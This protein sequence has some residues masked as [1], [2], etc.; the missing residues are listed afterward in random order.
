MVIFC[1]F[2]LLVETEVLLLVRDNFEGDLYFWT[3]LPGDTL[4]S[5]LK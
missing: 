2:G 4:R 3:A 1:L 5:A